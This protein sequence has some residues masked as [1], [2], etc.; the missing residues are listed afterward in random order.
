MFKNKDMPVDLE[1]AKVGLY[2]TYKGIVTRIQ[3]VHSPFLNV[4][5][6]DMDPILLQNKELFAL[7]FTSVR[8]TNYGEF[9]RYSEKGRRMMLKKSG[10]NP[11]WTIGFGSEYTDNEIMYVH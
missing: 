3:E 1:M 6:H 11:G 10:N 7:N 2:F 9:E 5:C 4:M 8:E